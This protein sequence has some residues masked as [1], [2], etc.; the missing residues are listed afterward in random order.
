MAYPT[1]WSERLRLAG[2]TCFFGSQTFGVTAP[3]VTFTGS[4]TGFGFTVAQIGDIDNDG[5]PDIAISDSTVGEKVYI[6][7]GRS[8]WPMN[9]TD[10]Q[11][12]YVNQ[13]RRDI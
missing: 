3:A 11:A 8:S 10:A 13:R 6:Y 5:L 1:S 7:K 9:L 4:T 12:D 2:P